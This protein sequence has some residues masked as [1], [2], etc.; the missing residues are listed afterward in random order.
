MVGFACIYACVPQGYSV[1]GGKTEGIGSPGTGLSLT[2]E[3]AIMWVLEKQSVLSTP[4]PH[5]LNFRDGSLVVLIVKYKDPN[6]VI[7]VHF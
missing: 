7:F 2:C 5:W 6:K 3:P 1:H 4:Q